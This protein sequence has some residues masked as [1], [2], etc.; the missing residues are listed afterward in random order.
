MLLGASL[1]LAGLA[2]CRRPVEEIVPYVTAPEEIVPGIPRHYATTMPFRRSAYG[3]IVESHE[4]RPTKVEGNPSHP[5][6]LGASSARVQ[7]SVLGLYDPDRSQSVTQNGTRKSWS[8]FVTAWGPLS[9]AHA[10]DG[11]ASLAVVSESFSSPTLARL[12]SELRA[13]YPRLQWATY[14]AVS[15]ESRLA[16]LRQATGRDLDLML[17]LDRASVILALDADPLLTDPEMI[18]HTRGFADGRRAGASGGAMNRLYAVEGGLLADRSDGGSSAPSREPADRALRLGA[19][20]TPCSARRWRRERTGTRRT[21]SRRALDRRACEGPSG[22]PRQGVDRGGRAPARRRPRGGV[23]AEHSSRQHRQDGQLLRDEGRCASERQLARL[24]RLGDEVGHDQDAR[25]PGR[26]SG[27]RCPCRSRLRFGD[28]EGPSV[29]RA[30]ALSRRNIRQGN[31]ARSPRALPRIVGRR[32]RR[33]RHA[34]RRPAADPPAVR[35]SKSRRSAG[36]DGRGPGSSRPRHRA[37]DMET[38]PGRGRVRQ[39]MEPRPA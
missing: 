13:R 32:A 38:N 23:R 20:R 21:R 12:V 22:E 4:G 26:Q 14:D 1:S 5:S 28:G 10:A 16:G 11:G 30:R 31:L 24:T 35:R 7:A 3:L 29:D 6:T 34:Q 17:R 39:E 37:R 18:R 33:R 2:G 19:R 15:D 9:E 8:D 36:A 27:I 25:C